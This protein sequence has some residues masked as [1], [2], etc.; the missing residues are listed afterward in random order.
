M[1]CQDHGSYEYSYNHSEIRDLQKQINAL[2]KEQNEAKPEKVKRLEDKLNEANSKL[3]EV[4]NLASSF[5]ETLNDVT[6]LLCEATYILHKENLLKDKPSLKQWFKEHT[7]EDAT[8]MN[9]EI[10]KLLR[11][12]QLKPILTWIKKLNEKEQWVFDNH[13]FF[14]NLN[15]TNP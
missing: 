12:G 4:D 14:K 1:P 5:A 3:T 2:T 7:E 6:G 15:F 11:K 8:R 10:Q 9:I 13:K